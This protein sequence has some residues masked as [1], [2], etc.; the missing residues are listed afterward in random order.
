MGSIEFISKLGI[1]EILKPDYEYKVKR[2][3]KILVR[4]GEIVKE[5]LPEITVFINR[6]QYKDT[7]ERVKLSTNGEYILFNPKQ[8]LQDYGNGGY[9]VILKQ[10]LHVVFHIIL[11]HLENSDG[12]AHLQLW[13]ATADLEVS[14]IC[15]Q[16]L[17]EKNNFQMI[18]YY[19][20][21]K[22]EKEQD[23]LGDIYEQIKSDQHSYWK[24][25]NL[26]KKASEEAQLVLFGGNLSNDPI[27]RSRQLSKLI[28]ALGGTGMRFSPDIFIGTDSG[29][30]IRLHNAV[31]GRLDWREEIYQI[32]EEDIKNILTADNFDKA[33]YLYGLELYQDVPIIEPC[34]EEEARLTSIDITIALDTSGSCGWNV[35]D[36]FLGELEGIL[37]ALKQYMNPEDS[38]SILECDTKIQ[39]E[40]VLG[41]ND[42]FPGC[43]SNKELHGFGGTS[44]IPVFEYACRKKNEKEASYSRKAIIIYLTDGYGEY[45][46]EEPDCTTIFVIPEKEPEEKYGFGER[47]LIPDY[48]RKVYM[49]EIN[50]IV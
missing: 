13:N 16:L 28:N 15:K 39:N 49:G 30:E 37:C 48:I 24:K 43:M 47:E 33:L 11:G 50:E 7:A 4:V 5:C 35:A 2:S 45:P 17:G 25:S 8:L 26:L 44:F 32:L 18:N 10:Y 3:K 1:D 14:R 27:E 40:T 29:S 36:R 6:V 19:D 12:I 41:I 46:G 42:I 31:Y 22:N 34:E 20:L 38:I 23:K 21:K 9:M